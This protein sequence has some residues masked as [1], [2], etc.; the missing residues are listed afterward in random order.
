MAIDIPIYPH[1][2][3]KWFFVRK[4]LFQLLLPGL[5]AAI[6]FFGYL[7]HD[8]EGYAY[9]DLYFYTM[10]VLFCYQGM[11]YLLEYIFAICS[12]DIVF[13]KPIDLERTIPNIILAT[14]LSGHSD[15]HV[16]VI[17]KLFKLRYS[18][19]S[20]FI[21]M[22]QLCWFL[23]LDCP[24][25]IPWELI[26]DLDIDPSNDQMSLMTTLDRI[27]NFQPSIYNLVSDENVSKPVIRKS[28]QSIC[29]VKRGLFD[30]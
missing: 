22:T 11:K 30:V 12:D 2:N 6:S 14:D 4:G 7:V 8:E 19:S 1:R 9:T 28:D 10:I 25:L 17:K 5:L 20:L 27:Y 18:A 3:R 26:R 24:I 23:G 15:Q 16:I 29:D 21:K 13:K